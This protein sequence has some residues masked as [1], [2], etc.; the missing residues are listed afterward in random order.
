MQHFLPSWKKI[1]YSSQRCSEIIFFGFTC[2]ILKARSQRIFNLLRNYAE[3]RLSSAKIEG[4]YA[5]FSRIIVS[6]FNK[7]STKRI[8]RLEKVWLGRNCKISYKT[9]RPTYSLFSRD[10][11]NI[12]KC[13]IADPW[14]FNFLWLLNILH[15]FPFECFQLDGKL[16]FY[17]RSFWISVF[18]SHRTSRRPTECVTYV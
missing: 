4:Y 11:I 9:W 17:S 18:P 3:Y 15:T 12:L 14:V 8:L 7:L 10:V 1:S 16:C 2:V 5:R 6:L 13:K